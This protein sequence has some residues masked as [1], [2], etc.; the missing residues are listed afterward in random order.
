MLAF[1]SLK[2]ISTTFAI[3]GLSSL[4][5]QAGD[6][7]AIGYND[8]GIWTAVIYYCSSTAKGGSD[9]KDAA[10]ARE[11]ALK[12]L[13]ARAGEHQATSKIIASSDKTGHF[14]VASARASTAEEGSLHLFLA[15]RRREVRGAER[16]F[17]KRNPR[18][19]SPTRA[20]YSHTLRIAKR[21]PAAFI[22]FAQHG[23]LI[24]QQP[25]AP[26]QSAELEV[27]LAVPISPRATTAMNRYFMESS[28]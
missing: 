20:R 22:Y 17:G 6:A 5:A 27:A 12:D 10:G 21:L 9:F 14:A 13:K 8:K 26:Q 2:V 11:A 23:N 4:I 3:L 7:V 18:R 1:M 19:I 25:P 28:C 16:S 15:R 24:G